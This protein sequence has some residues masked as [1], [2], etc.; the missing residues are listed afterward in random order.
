MLEG[1]FGFEVALKRFGVATL[2]AMKSLV[3]LL[4]VFLIT[5]PHTSK[6]AF[7]T[8]PIPQSPLSTLPIQ[9]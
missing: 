6:V 2:W 3:N 7:A 8:A 1:M 9:R 4:Y 5:I